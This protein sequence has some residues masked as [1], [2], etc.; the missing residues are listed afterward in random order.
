MKFGRMFATVSAALVL[1]VV[2]SAAP[3]IAAGPSWGA[4]QRIDTIT[5][6]SPAGGTVT[7]GVALTSVSCPS[8][9]FC[10]ATDF[11]NQYLIFNGTSW[12]TPQTLGTFSLLPLVSCAS[13]DMCVAVDADGDAKIWNGSS[14]G[15]SAVIDPPDALQ[16]PSA[17]GGISCPTT[18]FCLAGDDRGDDVVYNGSGWSTP[19]QAGAI[20][21][22]AAS[23]VTGV[24]CTSA[25]FC[26]AVTTDPDGINQV[27]DAW[28]YNGT[29]WD[30]TANQID[31]SP[32]TAVSCAAQSFCAGVDGAG[33]AV[34]YNGST[35][36]APNQMD[37]G[38]GGLDSV[39][40]PAETFCAAVDTNGNVVTYNGSTWNTPQHLDTT[41]AQS[42]ATPTPTQLNSVSCSTQSFC[43]A[44]DE[45]GNAVIDETPPANTAP[46][47][48]AG[49]TQQGNTLTATTGT[50]SGSPTAFAYHWQDCTGASCTPIAGATSSTYAL[51]T[52]D[53]GHTIE[54]A[55]T[56]TNGGGNSTPVSSA[57][58]AAVTAIPP[59][60]PPAPNPPPPAAS[61]PTAAQITAALH[62]L[63][64]PT[65]KAATIGSILKHGGV[66]LSFT[67]PGAG[68]LTIDW[69]LV[70]KHG[71]KTVKTVVAKGTRTITK[72]GKT[73]VTIKLTGKGKQL[74][75]HLKKTLKL[76]MTSAFTP[77]GGKPT[78]VSRTLKLK[79]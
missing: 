56:A 52:G 35:W 15:P 7:S 77:A 24:S 34:T 78:T 22:D 75:K 53:V 71:K 19:Q 6:S 50:W 73:T 1:T 5:V 12:S 58:T 46:P 26:A 23:S 21:G 64:G 47:T 79:P 4:P 14:W 48:I 49:T 70:V 16:L 13:A 9:S 41:A 38:G 36:S 31:P 69:Y 25:T 51:T 61:G 8:T 54:V 63:H 74:F 18:S 20:A 11:L 66:A 33:D 17:I 44:V 62:K 65:G 42:S 2:A 59:T 37:N 76:T 39:S 60:P 10:M 3:A 27:G 57:P 28:T 32:F 43:V 67:A 29:A 40:C 45:H 72:P 30:S 55:V 68:K